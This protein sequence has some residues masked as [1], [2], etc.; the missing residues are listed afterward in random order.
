[1]NNMG[2]EIMAAL[3]R[4]QVGSDGDGV[5]VGGSLVVSGATTANTFSATNV[6][7]SGN[8]TFTGTGNRITG[9][10]SNATENNRVTFQNSVTNQGTNVSAIPNG[11]NQS[12][13]FQVF[14]NSD[15]TNASLNQI[16][17]TASEAQYQ[18]GITGTGSYLPMT[19][20]TGGSERMRIDTS[21][22][23]GIGTSSPA[24]RLQ[25]V[26]A[27]GFG[28]GAAGS[29]ATI[30]STTTGNSATTLGFATGSGSTFDIILLA[31]G[32]SPANGVV[33]NQRNNAPMAFNTNNTER[34]RIDSSGNVMV[35]TTSV[36][37][38]GI[39]SVIAT[40][41]AYV[42]RVPNNSFSNFVGQNSSG[43]L[44]FF[45]QGSGTINAVNT[46]ITAISDQ[47]LK[48]N[49]QDIDVGL[50]AVMALKPRKFDWKSG[51]GKDIKGDRGW[52]AQE[53]E[54]VFPEMVSTW[55][56]SPP[57]GE[58]PYKAVG[59]NLIPVL[60]KAIQELKAELDTVKAELNQLKG[61]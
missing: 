37:E 7:A 28:N 53:F 5:T 59:A 29:A 58:E 36:L 54:Q 46:T 52:I 43:S 42:G 39:V 38:N 24:S 8:L 20:Y 31:A 41:N 14:N 27:A 19:F 1:M 56:G 16:V 44:T 2:R 26:G 9:D 50:D 3:K 61:N 57:D 40:T 51:K 6:T 12:S 55:L 32:A 21:G 30:S 23:V 15:K 49:I 35:N 48:E 47:R 18:S 17:A 13:R 4:F 60:T 25:V 45:V 22:N 34:M 11:T 33:L 10:M